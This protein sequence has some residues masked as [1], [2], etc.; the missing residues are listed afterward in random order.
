MDGVACIKA[1]KEFDADVN[2]LIC[3]AL[4]NKNIIFEA[5]KSGAFDYIEKPFEEED[6]VQ[7]LK[8]FEKVFL[9]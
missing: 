3:S 7:K 8:E 2:I 5:L 9:K 1:L 6:F 4:G